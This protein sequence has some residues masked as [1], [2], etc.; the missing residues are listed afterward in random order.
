MESYVLPYGQMSLWGNLICPKCLEYDNVFFEYLIFILIY[1]KYN[2]TVALRVKSNSRL[3]PHNIN[4]IEIIYG[5][6]LGDSHAERRSTGHGTRIIFQQEARQKE[7]LL[8]LHKIVSEL[9]YCNPKTPEI[10]TRLGK[11]GI[12]RQV[13]RFR[14]FTYTSLNSVHDNWYNNGM[15]RVPHDI[16]D[17]LTPLSLAI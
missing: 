3:G 2:N 9:G 12:I 10:I 4:I 11:G 14:T 8:F 6:L 5:T 15:K 1:N 17:Y 7:Y 16:S 13:I